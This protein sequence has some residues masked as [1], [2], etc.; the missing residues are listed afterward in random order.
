RW[1]VQRLVPAKAEVEGEQ[2]KVGF[3]LVILLDDITLR[4]GGLELVLPNTTYNVAEIELDAAA[5]I[6]S[7]AQQI[8]LNRLSLRLPDRDLHLRRSEAKVRYVAAGQRIEVDGLHLETAASKLH[9]HV[10]AELKGG[11][12]DIAVDIDNLSAAE[13]RRITGGELPVADV[14]GVVRA[15][16]PAN[17][18]AIDGSRLHSAEAELRGTGRLD[19]DNPKL[20]YDL[21]LTIAK[22]D[23]QALLGP[24]RPQTEINGAVK[25]TGSGF[26]PE[27]IAATFDVALHD[28]VVQQTRFEQLG[29]QGSFV[30]RKLK[31]EATARTAMGN[32]LL[33]AAVDLAQQSYEV[34]LT[35]DQFD[36]TPFVNRPELRGRING[37]VTVSGTGFDPDTARASATVQ[38]AGSNVGAI[39]VRSLQVNAALADALLTVQQLTLDTNAASAEASGQIELKQA[40]QR[41]ADATAAQL[42]Y[43]LQV[44]DL[45][46]LAR[47]A[48]IEKASGA[49]TLNGTASGR[50]R[51]LDVEA[52]LDGQKITIQGTEIARLETRISGRQLG[53]P[54]ATAEVQA[55]VAGLR[56]GGRSFRTAQ[57]KADWAQHSQQEGTLRLEVA[58]VESDEQ[59]HSL[60]G[61]AEIAPNESRVLLQRL[62]LA[63]A[64]QD[65]ATTG[66]SR[67]VWRKGRLQIEGLE[68]R[69]DAGGLFRVEGEGGTNG[70][71][72]LRLTVSGVALEPLLGPSQKGVSGT[73]AVRVEL[74]GS[75]AQPSVTANVEIADLTTADIRYQEVQAELLV[76][77]GTAALIA[78]VVQS[79]DNQLA[80]DA[81]V[82]LR[83]ALSPFR[84]ELGESLSGTLR[85]A[86]IDL[87]FLDPLLPP[88][89]NLGGTFNATLTLGG[90]LREPQIDGSLAIRDGRAYVVPVGLKYDPIQLQLQVQG[91]RIAIETLRITSG[92][93]NLTGAGT[94]ERG[95]DGIAG[96]VTL[97]LESFPLFDN[98]YGEGST[99]GSLRIRGSAAAPMVEGRFDL[100]R[101][102]IKIPEKLPGGVRPPDPTIQVIGPNAAV[103]E[104]AAA[105]IEPAEGVAA[106]A[107]AEAEVPR[108]GIYER[109][110]VKVDVRVTNNAWLRR[111]DTDIE[112]RGSLTISKEPEQPL[113]V[114]GVINT[115]RGWYTFQGRKFTVEEGEVN[116]S[117][118]G[119][120]PLLNI[121]AV[122]TAGEYTIRARI[123]GS[124]TKPTIKLESEPTLDQADILSVLLFGKPASALNQGE[125][126]ALRTQA[127]AVASSYVAA[128]FRQSVASA[129]GVDTLEVT[130]GTE[131]MASTSASVGKYV[132]ED[133]F[134]SLAHKFADQ[135]TVEELTIQY[136][137]SRAWTIETSADTRGDSGIDIFWRRRY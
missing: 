102:M 35:A 3:Q 91:E 39:E 112:L 1:N 86:E 61:T 103:I 24:A 33:S 2:A 108:V 50:L 37:T 8:E 65:W 90:T 72:D 121:V 40:L 113:S 75:A 13:I 78:R 44:K 83:L 67:L 59:R 137:L 84:Y 128:E 82:P 46:P 62:S 6:E 109:A 43:H 21:T 89:S 23:A 55:D 11:D 105:G 32:A 73:A 100:D 51:A 122:Y 28:S 117:G 88:V 127:V 133:I 106:E 15:Q 98:R 26:R 63:I 74:R 118:Q 42:R 54:H 96:D 111:S 48:N 79:G 120:D 17:A 34:K 16:G 115:V 64:D 119:F 5:K 31:A 52:T 114:A 131:G 116:L 123:G 22:L 92:D 45:A 10:D 20:G 56:A 76:E 57:V 95:A 36:T 97:T 129:L 125:S 4:D 110:T 107:E 30:E 60:Q 41:N 53:D 9:G 104:T 19:L 14:R 132:T 25:V 81:Q 130:P 7:G 124:V 126:D 58:A 77:Q 38:I 136:F 80:L 27:E 70:A 71:Q 12:F 135:Q 101:L 29:A 94:L 99:N 87:A 68:L 47:L 85:A 18:I 66:E 69:S 93:G 134:V 49:L